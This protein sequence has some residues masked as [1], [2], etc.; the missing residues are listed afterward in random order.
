VPTAHV[1]NPRETQPVCGELVCRLWPVTLKGIEE[2]AAGLSD[3][4]AMPE[5]RRFYRERLLRRQGGA[6]GDTTK[7]YS[8]KGATSG[9]TWRGGQKPESPGL[10]P[11][12]IPVVCAE[13]PLNLFSTLAMVLRP[14][15]VVGVRGYATTRSP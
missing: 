4:A 15:P 5:T 6:Q 9:V 2:P 10:I 13:N 8:T 7:G 3:V 1:P 12:S 11:L 14:R